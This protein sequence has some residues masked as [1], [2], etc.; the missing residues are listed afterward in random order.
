MKHVEIYRSK[1][2]FAG[3][4]AN[5]GIWSWGDEIVVGFLVGHLDTETDYFHA[6][7]KSKPFIPHQSRSLD[8]GE[9]WTTVPIPAASPGS[10][11]FSADD[12]MEDH[13][14]ILPIID[15]TNRP[16]PHPGDVDMTHP[17]LRCYV[18]GQD[19]EP[20]P[21]HGSIP[22]STAADPGRGLTHCRILA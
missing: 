5:F 9:T 22:Q 11:G 7:D 21:C 18:R 15:D 3:W 1:G 2:H 14:K 17:D 12:Q 13:L 16:Q 8:G 4:P 19:F 6:R 10:R 20:A